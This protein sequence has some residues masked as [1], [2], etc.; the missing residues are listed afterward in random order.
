MLPKKNRLT[1]R[2]VSRIFSSGTKI[3]YSPLFLIL[4][5]PQ[6]RA[7]TRVQ[8]SVV[9]GKNVSKKA[10]ERNRIRRILYRLLYQEREQFPKKQFVVVTTKKMI[11]A[12]TE[13]VSSELKKAIKAI[14]SV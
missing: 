4:H 3:F 2:E 6:S 14:H 10:V 8:C 12:P 5:I 1:R 7:Q 9:V 11:Q 13:E